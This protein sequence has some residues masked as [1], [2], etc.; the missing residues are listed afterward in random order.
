MQMSKIIP[1]LFALLFTNL[2]SAHHEEF[3]P[4]NWDEM[5]EYSIKI[6][7]FKAK[8]FHK[9]PYGFVTVACERTDKVVIFDDENINKEL[10]KTSRNVKVNQNLL[11]L[12]ILCD[13]IEDIRHPPSKEVMQYSKMAKAYE[14]AYKLSAELYHGGGDANPIMF[15]EKAAI[16]KKTADKAFLMFKDPDKRSAWLIKYYQSIISKK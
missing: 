7:P 6:D 13:A 16:I 12:L 1:L 8:Y 15:I 4:I 3:H 5:M 9:F 11:P 10:D 2:V 14:V